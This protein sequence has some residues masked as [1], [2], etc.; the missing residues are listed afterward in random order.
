[1]HSY[2]A[3]RVPV[4]P[5]VVDK[6]VVLEEVDL[7]ASGLAAVVVRSVRRNAYRRRILLVPLDGD[8][9]RFLSIDGT[10]E[11]HPRFCAGSSVLAYV[12]R[13]LRGRPGVGRPQVWVSDLGQAHPPRQLTETPHGVEA[14][15]WSPAGD[16]IAYWGPQG[17]SRSLHFG[18]R[19]VSPTARVIQKGGWRWDERGFVD[20]WTHLSVI[21]LHPGSRSRPVTDGEFNVLSADWDAD[22]HSIV[23]TAAIHPLA[24]LY[25]RPS[26]YRI[27]TDGH[28]N[29]S[30]V[31]VVRLPGTVDEVTAS[32]D[33]RWLALVGTH[34]Q[35]APDWALPSLYLTQAHGDGRVIH[36]AP[37][38]EQPITG[39]WIDT[40]L[41][42]WASPTRHGPFWIHD[43]EGH[44]L[45]AVVSIAGRSHP[46]RFPY[47]V[48]DGAAGAP[49]QLTNGD[50]TVWQMAMAA[51]R[52]AALGTH[53]G[54]AM[55]LME[56]VNGR[57]RTITN[58][59]SRWQRRF[60]QPKMVHHRVPGRGGEIEMWVAGL[61]DAKCGPRATILNFHGGPRGAWSP[62]PSI[63]V[64][65]L[66]SAGYS[67]ALP[68][69]RG[70]A[71]YGADWIRAQREWG[72]ADVEDV[73]SVVDYLVDRGIADPSRIGLLG[74]SYGGFMVNY[75][76][77]AEPDRWAAAVSENGVTNHIFAW[78]GSDGG[79][80]YR[81]RARLGDP[82]SPAGV[83]QLWRQSPLR[84]AHRIRT[85]LLLLQGQNDRRTPAGDN[86]QLFLALRALGLR[87]EYVL[88]PESY[89]NYAVNGRPDR[90]KDRHERVLAWFNT[91][92]R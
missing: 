80:D 5:D 91:Y 48:E 84:N 76:V 36:L 23:F 33:G 13:G 11:G 87:T 24:D 18:S 57:Y 9:Q 6:Q 39:W 26:V 38:L 31:E 34:V 41:H 22:G 55:E 81:R 7:S 56:L 61:D 73:L 25:P 64:Q 60:V 14:F 49:R 12:R 83:R 35:G 15:V 74:L 68:N 45:V 17:E 20:Y 10:D 21:D 69:I 16:R 65:I 58:R 27:N 54:R 4:T 59:G 29:P 2:A 44:A 50:T 8:R 47:D 32:P 46:W 62:A 88:Y 30:P 78:A 28:D 3:R 72:A 82:L 51:G 90:R 89:H 77:G 53:G 67:V 75:L 1:M 92:L 70:S 37:E 86:E 42:G 71:T 63:E 66:A 79:P 52:L 85:P 19:G 43:G 40:D